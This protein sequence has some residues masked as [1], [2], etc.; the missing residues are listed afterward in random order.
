MTT[1]SNILLVDTVCVKNAMVYIA[2]KIMDI[3]VQL[4]NN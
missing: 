1:T 2:I 3:N 4:V